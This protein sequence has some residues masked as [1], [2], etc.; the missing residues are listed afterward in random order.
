MKFRLEK[1]QIQDI[2]KS[3]SAIVNEASLNPI[4]ACI[5]VQVD[6]NNNKIN[7]T[8]A[9]ERIAFFQSIDNI[10]A[11]EDFAFCVRAKIF[12][13]V[14]SKLN[15]KQVVFEKI[16]STLR[17]SNEESFDCNINLSEAM[18]YPE[19]RFEEY[20]I[21]NK[22]M[23]LKPTQLAAIYNETNVTV[24]S[25]IEMSS[26]SI[27]LGGIHF[28]TRDNNIAIL[29]TDSFRASYLLLPNTLNQKFEFIIEPS[30][31]KNVIDN[32]IKAENI[33]VFL[34]HEKLFFKWDNTIVLVRLSLAGNY[35]NIYNHFEKELNSKFTVKAKNLLNIL[36]S[37]ASLVQ[38]EK[39]PTA[40]I[41]VDQNKIEIRYQSLDFGSSYESTKWETF[42]GVN[43]NC[44][45]NTK[46]LIPIL[47]VYDAEDT[48]EIKFSEN[49]PMI[50]SQKDNTD[51]KHLVLPLRS[52]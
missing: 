32:A 43:L 48:L 5:L 9:N 16:D 10:S 7:F 46:L 39:V 41:T 20:K 49:S 27:I 17:I 22:I 12:V 4:L 8:Y 45:V 19:F 29:S 33:E 1:K 52:A 42:N 50:I 14:L 21:A 11:D 40:K 26:P 28:E 25:N 36:E 24:A 44:L 47:R 18:Q 30:S 6:A 2:I 38:N 15:V 34:S 23:D 13:G 35:P 31:L 51:L 3:S 37:G